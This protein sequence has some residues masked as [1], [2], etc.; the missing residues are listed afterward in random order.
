MQYIGFTI[1][2]NEYTIP[3]LK[4]QEIINM[5]TITKLPQSA[6]YIEGVTNLRGRIIQIVNLKKLAGLYDSDTISPTGKVIVIT[7]G[8]MTFG[9][10]VDSITG[11]IS[12]NNSDIEPSENFMQSHVAQIE[13]VAR[14]QDRLVVMLDTKKLIP[15]EDESLFE[16]EI[17]EVKET[18]GNKVEVTKK[19]EGMGGEIIVKEVLDAKDFFTHKGIDPSDPRFA[20]VDDMIAFMNAINKDDL[21]QADA[22]IQKMMSR[23]QA[24]LFKEVGKVT[25]KLHDSI[26]TFRDAIDPRLRDIAVSDMPNAVDR[27]HYVIE[28]TEEAANKTM[29]IVEKHLLEL[30]DFSNHVRNIKEPQESVE[31]LKA[32]KNRLEDDLTEIITTQ[33]FQDLTGQTIKKV[34]VLV[35]D[36]EAEL[37]KLIATFGVK[38]DQTKG[39]SEQEVHEKVSQSDVDD[40]LKDFGF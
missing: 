28:K 25:R 39:I 3:I 10:L 5:P 30:D 22:A 15:V 19:I 2:E 18:N 27:L 33:S 13:G 35:S 6:D 31:Y 37:V 40:L 17:F 16:D 21:E 4:V 9:I 23:G 29:A 14:V 24:D 1:G 7:S 38:I 34:I 12:I 20:I 32:F 11:V 8:K 26:K 36:I